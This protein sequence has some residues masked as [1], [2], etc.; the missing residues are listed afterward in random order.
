[1][2][3]N[4][5]DD[6]PVSVR[7]SDKVEKPEETSV[8]KSESV[9]ADTSSEKTPEK[10]EDSEYI[11]VEDFVEDFIVD[12]SEEDS[13]A[14]VNELNAQ[15]EH[16]SGLKEAHDIDVFPH[17]TIGDVKIDMGY[18]P[19]A[20]V[21][22]M[23]GEDAVVKETD[24]VRSYFLSD[25][26]KQRAMKS[27]G[28]DSLDDMT[29][30]HQQVYN[31]MVNRGKELA[32]NFRVGFIDR[33]LRDTVH[34]CCVDDNGVT[35]VLL[36]PNDK[37]FGMSILA[38]E[39]GHHLY[40]PDYINPGIHGEEREYG[41]GEQQYGKEGSPLSTINEGDV[42]ERRARLVYEGF[43]QHV[44][45]F[46]SQDD[47]KAL[48][49]YVDEYV[50]GEDMKLHDNAGIER[51]ADVHGVRMLMMQEGIWNPF[52]GEPVTTKQIKEFRKAH[53]DCRIFEYWNNKEAAYYL[54]N[55]AMSDK[56]KPDG[57]RVNSGID[58]QYHLVATV[59]GSEVDKVIS[60]RDYDKL[61]ALDD[62]KR[63]VLLSKLL[64]GNGLSFD[65]PDG[66]PL[67]ELLAHEDAKVSGGQSIDDAPVTKTEKADYLAMSAANFESISQD[68]DEGQQQHRGMS[69]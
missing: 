67:G 65:F 1:M 17:P 45:Q 19:H 61:M 5:N 14:K 44:S 27:L 31:D 10:D 57:I 66:V 13:E 50:K 69:V 15:A 2:A 6:K 12:S 33:D 52:T 11:D 55:I 23:D 32:V 60:Q 40:N 49:K 59:G 28:Y 36:N 4:K 35:T 41:G 20:S 64:D 68:L 34:S 8:D 39:L 58:G 30:E 25:A 56:I 47:D 42:K 53:P 21:E 26:F 22:G 3:E 37:G 9:Q 62:G 18:A 48:K 63:G 46:A 7:N 24:L 54:N 38:H 51:A 43:F 16:L 29:P